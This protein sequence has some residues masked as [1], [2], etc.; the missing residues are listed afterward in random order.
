MLLGLVY[1]TAGEM[2]VLGRPMPKS[3][4]DVLPEVG[5]LVEGPAYYPHMSGRANLA[6]MDAAGPGGPRRTRTKRIGGSLDRVGLGDID[7]RPVK[8]YSSGMKQRLGL[9]AALLRPHRLLILD[10]P[11][12][13]LDPH[14]MIEIRDLLSELVAGGA[15]ILLSS[16]LLAEVE[17]ICTRA[18]IVHAGRLVAQD[19]V[20]HLLAPTGRALIDTPDAA[21]VADALARFDGV[22]VEER[23]GPRV[24]VRLNGMKPEAF[25]AELV[26]SGIRVREM[27]LERSTLEQVFLNLTRRDEAGDPDVHR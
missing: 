1:A 5:S 23:I 4:R 22:R 20:E 2:E 8:T 7:R 21:D 19:S 6:L 14:G 24:T 12:N 16:H 26:R 15:T 17:A 13:G 3:A 11:T 27:V 25:T 9:A 18:A 10:E